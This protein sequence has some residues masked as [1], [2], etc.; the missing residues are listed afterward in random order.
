VPAPPNQPMKLTGPASLLFETQRR[1]S[2]PGNLSWSFGCDTRSFR[3][4]AGVG[5]RPGQR[6]RRRRGVPGRGTLAGC[7]ASWWRSGSVRAGVHA[8]EPARANRCRR[9]SSRFK[10]N[11]IAN[12]P[13]Q[14][15][16]GPFCG[17][18]T[19]SSAGAAVAERCDYEAVGESSPCGHYF[20]SVTQRCQSPGAMIVYDVVDR[21]SP[22]NREDG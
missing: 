12:N 9:E 18:E 16:R 2:R 17:S 5:V 14:T 11:P 20:Q 21:S 1:C 8:V 13:L 22:A 4:P 6:V 7:A 15:D 19:L 3:L 10:I